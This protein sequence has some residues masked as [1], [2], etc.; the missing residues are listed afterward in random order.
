MLRTARAKY[1][2]AVA[3]TSLIAVTASIAGVGPAS[4][5]SVSTWDRVAQCESGGNWS[6]NTG[7]GYYGGLQFSSGTWAA[8]GGTGYASQAHLATK[9]QQ[10][11]IGEKVLAVQGE[12]A[13]PSCGPN[14][15]LGSDH[16]D[17]YPQTPPTPA[18]RNVQLDIVGGDGGMYSQFG[19]YQQGRFNGSWATVGGASLT[20]I[21]SANVGDDLVHFYGVSGGRVYGRDHVPSENR[22][23]SWAEIPGGATGVKDVAAS[24]SGNNVVLSM[25]GGDG[26]LYT[27]YG[28]YDQGRFDAA[29]TKRNGVGLTSVTSVSGN[30]NTIRIYAVGGG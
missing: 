18:T 25:V 16:A 1:A 5:A 27:Q 30:S 14:A 26:V 19:N 3:L 2:P 12:G 24:T 28:N 22:W 4:A 8:F 7:N 13:W 15:A 21:T 29:W 9:Q 11:L 17:P 10:I 20:K 23:T 6:I